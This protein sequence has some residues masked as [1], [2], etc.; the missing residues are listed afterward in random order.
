MMSP[1][2]FVPVVVLLL[3]ALAACGDRHPGAQPSEATKVL[4]VP[5]AP[6]QPD[7]P[8]VQPVAPNANE[9][10][11]PVEVVAMPLPGQADDPE[12]VALLNSERS[13]A[14]DVLK[15]PELAKLANS[16]TALEAWR[17]KALRRAQLNQLQRSRGQ[18]GVVKKMS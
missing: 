12:T 11:K 10:A 4:G 6:P 8:G 15:D 13:E 18:Q 17:R 2:G 14:I 1:A 7:P 5:P 9:L 16:D 3:S